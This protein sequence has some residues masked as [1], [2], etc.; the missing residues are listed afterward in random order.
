MTFFLNYTSRLW[1]WDVLSDFWLVASYHNKNLFWRKYKYLM[2]FEGWITL[3][4]FPG[5]EE[6]SKHLKV[7]QRYFWSFYEMATQAVTNLVWNLTLRTETIS[8]LIIWS[9]K[10][11]ICLAT[12]YIETPF[13]FLYDSAPEDKKSF[14]QFGKTTTGHSSV[15]PREWFFSCMGEIPYSSWCGIRWQIVVLI[16]LAFTGFYLTVH[17]IKLFFKETCYTIV[18]STNLLKFG[19]LLMN[20]IYWNLTD[21]LKRY[22]KFNTARLTHYKTQFIF[23]WV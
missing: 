5:V 16:L 20:H 8:V 22:S 13:L 12:V 18:G 11:L 1:L 6:S 19:W 21:G 7:N 9:V 14:S 3:C 4:C 15:R 23:L 17:D 10:T 2:I